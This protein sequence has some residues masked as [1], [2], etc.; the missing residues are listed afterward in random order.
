MRAALLMAPTAPNSVLEVH[1]FMIDRETGLW[2]YNKM[3]A[4]RAFEETAWT[5][6]T[7]N[8]VSYTHLDVYKRQALSTR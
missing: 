4:I 2:I 1:P 5:L 7:E 6:F 8:T 3:N